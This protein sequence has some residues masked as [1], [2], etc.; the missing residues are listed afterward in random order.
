[1]PTLN[2][3]QFDSPPSVGEKVIVK[4]IIE[5]INT[6]TGEV[7]VTYDSVEASAAEDADDMPKEETVDDAM[8]KAFPRKGNKEKEMPQE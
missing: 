3:E 7:E 5:S 6:E 2:L 8:E 4:G 1:M